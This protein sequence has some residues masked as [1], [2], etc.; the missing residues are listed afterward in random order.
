M[1][2]EEL[3]E[4]LEVIINAQ[5]TLNDLHTQ[6]LKPGLNLLHKLRGDDGMEDWYEGIITSMNEEVTANIVSVSF[7]EWKT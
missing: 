7:G 1:T 5:T 4:Q 3:K 2:V 6:S